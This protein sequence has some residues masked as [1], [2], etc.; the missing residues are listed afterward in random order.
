MLRFT[1]DNDIELKIL[2]NYQA[3]EIFELIDNCRSRL[4]KWLPWV[5]DTQSI[6]D[7]EAFIDSTKNQFASKNG[8]HSGIYYKGN[9]AGIIGYHKI[10][11]LNK[12]TSIGYWLGNEYLGNEYLGKGIIIKSAKVLIDHA[13]VDLNL[14]RVEIRCA[15]YNLESRA[16]PESLG[17]TIEGVVM[18]SKWLYDHYVDC[19]IYG[20]LAKEWKEYN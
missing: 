8:F 5:D 17:F 14:N 6:K 13:L 16:I 18:D 12:S 7:T 15:K 1:V 2:D 19:I 20:M 3:K 9:L 4:R 10:D 11:W